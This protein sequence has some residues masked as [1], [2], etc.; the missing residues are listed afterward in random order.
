MRKIQTECPESRLRER[1][2]REGVKVEKKC[3][4]YYTLGFCRDSLT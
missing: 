1:A 3:N 4:I 2:F